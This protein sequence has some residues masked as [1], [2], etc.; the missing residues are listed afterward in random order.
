MG[1][2]EWPY[3]STAR[4]RGL[5]LLALGVVKVATAEQLR[6]LVLPGTADLQTVR[7]ACKDL[8]YAGLMESV[9]RTS[10]P[11]AN[12]RPVRWDLWNLTMA[13]LAA[14]ASELGRPVREMGGTARDAA[15][16]GAAHA[17][18]VTDTIDAF[19]QSP[20][21]PT[22]PVARRTTRP[23]PERVLPVRPR[24]LGHLR[25][26]ETEVALPVT[27]T[28]T[29]PARGSLRADAVLTAPED[30]V[31]VLFVEVDNHTEPA[32]VV[33]AKIDRYSR[34]FRRQVKNDRGRDVALW[35]TLWDDSG[36]G[37]FPP[38]ALVFTKDVGAQA[39]MNRIKAV[40]D[41]SRTCWQP[42]WQ[43]SHSWSSNAS[44]DDGW[45]DFAGTVPVIATH[46]D[47]LRTHGP[48][49]PVWWRFGHSDWQPITDALT[50][51]GT[52]DEYHAREDQRREREAQEERRRQERE[53]GLRRREAGKW[54]C[55]S[56]GGPVYPGDAS[57]APVATGS[58]CTACRTLTDS[59]QPATTERAVTA[60]EAAESNGILA[61]LRRG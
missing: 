54:P 60:A 56:C 2:A 19:R 34:F 18:A 45:W 41:L 6:Q 40:R 37:G 53:E 55:P 29:T 20:P 14:A 4:A 12:G 1:R 27:G 23:A 25:G 28:F 36:R 17:L 8:R 24:G 33:A 30:L 3:N 42:R 48:H 26:W 16:A 58:P 51:T 9:G 7:N 15:K 46:L 22:K 10:S 61:R 21:L 31:P 43:K 57:G 50:N 13:G 47:Q 35:S 52:E 39:R 11:G 59:Q 49:G 5:V 38:V 44:E 32:A